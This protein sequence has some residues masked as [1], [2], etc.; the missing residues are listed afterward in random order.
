MHSM[1][2]DEKTAEQYVPFGCGEFVIQGQ[3]TGTPNTCINL[4]KLLTMTLNEGIDPFDNIKKSGPV[5][6]KPLSEFKSYDEFYAK[7][8]ELLDYYFD[9][10]SR[11]TRYI[12]IR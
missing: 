1:N 8:L 11:S 7:Y 2:V 9:L 3:S 4:L 6:I 5:N 10:S 12:L